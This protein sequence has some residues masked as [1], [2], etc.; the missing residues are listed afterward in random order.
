MQILNGKDLLSEA[1]VAVIL[2]GTSYKI[3]R[4]YSLIDIY[5]EMARHFESKKTVC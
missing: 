3:L 5:P 4:N 1:L 2:L